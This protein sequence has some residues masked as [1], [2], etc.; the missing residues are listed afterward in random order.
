M[1][2]PMAVAIDWSTPVTSPVGQNSGHCEWGCG[3][4]VSFLTSRS[5]KGPVA[6]IYCAAFVCIPEA[7][8][9]SMSAE[10]V[11]AVLADSSSGLDVSLA[12]KVAC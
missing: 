10:A 8:T 2:D 12:N 1:A 11:E 6:N 5:L 4:A 7:A 3:S 9:D